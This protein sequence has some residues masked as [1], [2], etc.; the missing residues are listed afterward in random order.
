MIGRAIMK[1]YTRRRYRLV[2]DTITNA[3]QRKQMGS[4]VCFSLP[5]AHGNCGYGR[6]DFQ[7]GKNQKTCTLKLRMQVRGRALQVPCRAAVEEPRG[8]SWSRRRPGESA[9]V[10]DAEH[11]ASKCSINWR[12]TR[13][14][15][16][17]TN[18]QPGHKK[19]TGRLDTFEACSESR[20]I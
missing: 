17:Y 18:M 1:L 15:G 13:W 16:T 3:R 7:F 6:H 12:W 19:A 4:Q 10:S 14:R 20:C 11:D 2:I 5:S 9:L 8:F